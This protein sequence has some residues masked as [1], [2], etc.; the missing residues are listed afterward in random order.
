MPIALGSVVLGA[1]PKVTP[2]GRGVH[3]AFPQVQEVGLNADEYFENQAALFVSL[4]AAMPVDVLETP[5]RVEFTDAELQTI[6]EAP[7]S[8][9]PT[10]LR[11]GV[12]K[13]L[14]SPIRVANLDAA[15]PVKGV[16]GLSEGSIRELEDGTLAWSQSITSDGA[17][18]IRVH[19][20]GTSLPDG[21]QMFFFSPEGESYGPYVGRGPNDSGEF[22]TDTVFSPTGV[23]MLVA[24]DADELRQATFTITDLGHISRQ[25]VTEV[26]NIAAVENFPCP[27]A[28][29]PACVLD[30]TC[31]TSGPAVPAK[32]GT[33]K[34]EW[35]A[36]QYIYTCTGG[37]INDTNPAQDNYFL[38]AN[39]CLSTN[40]T[41]A[42]VQFYWRFATSSC[43][44]TCPN[45]LINNTG[46]TPKTSGSV[47]RKTNRKGDYTLLQL[48][49]PP[50]AGSVFLG[51]TS[52]NVGIGVPLYRISNPN[53]GPQ[54][55]S[56]SNTFNYGFTC[57]GWPLTQR[58]YSKGV[59]G[60]TA[61]GSSGSP[62]LN[63]SSQIV[64]QLSGAC[65]TNLNNECDHN[66]NAT[67]DGRF[68]Y[69]FTAI[70]P[71]INP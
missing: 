4:Q 8:D 37:L 64:G 2:I 38:T 1:E 65:G 45:P 17:G 21:V 34:M 7:V 71:F 27:S 63:A 9:E 43:N 18:G 6:W 39:H 36:G 22:W 46:W 62:V 11:I 57:T 29:N 52:A 31:T 40:G 41:A 70:K 33:A 44:G 60:A 55:Y 54:V 23:L 13:A 24:T 48:N 25:F 5:I 47:V 32:L 15:G 53:F 68:S 42:T 30:A 59:N 61:G 12:V 49:G 16:R 69:Y 28:G 35:I 58:I 14:T 20:Q 50:P 19:L 3:E 26:I 56:N 67:V 10:P 66:S 51:W